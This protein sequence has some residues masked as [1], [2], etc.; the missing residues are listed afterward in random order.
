M[1]EV[2]ATLHIQHPQPLVNSSSK[3]TVL[4]SEKSAQKPAASAD[5]YINTKHDLMAPNILYKNYEDLT[6]ILYVGYVH[7]KLMIIGYSVQI[8]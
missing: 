6:N 4:N 1:H 7:W 3:E 5:H 2:F 8:S